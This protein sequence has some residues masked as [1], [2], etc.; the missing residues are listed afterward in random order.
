MATAWWFQKHKGTIM[1]RRGIWRGKRLDISRGPVSMQ[2]LLRN[3]DS[4]LKIMRSLEAKD[5]SDCS[6]E[7][8]MG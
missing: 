8:E 1:K 2:T 3:L 5:P 4:V 6:G 7:N